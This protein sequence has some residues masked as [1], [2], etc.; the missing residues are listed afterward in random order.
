MGPRELRRHCGLDREAEAALKDGHR[1]LSLSGRG[2][3][4]ALRVARTIADLKGRRALTKEDV[5]TAI[6]LRRRVER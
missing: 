5:L 1:T 6:N 3:D 4:R 2:W